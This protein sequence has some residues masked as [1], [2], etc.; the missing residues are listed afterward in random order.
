MINTSEKKVSLH[1]IFVILMSKID[2]IAQDHELHELRATIEAL[3]LQSIDG[4]LINGQ[5][6]AP[7]GMHN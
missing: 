1:I 3:R 7:L 5:A 4:G 2:F 6:L